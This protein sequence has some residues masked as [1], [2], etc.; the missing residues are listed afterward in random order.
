MAAERSSGSRGPA[1]D[2]IDIGEERG[3]RGAGGRRGC[4]ACTKQG[5]RRKKRKE[6]RALGVCEARLNT[7]QSAFGFRF[8]E[9]EGRVKGKKN[10]EV[11][12]M[13]ICLC[14]VV[15]PAT[16]KSDSQ[17]AGYQNTYIS[18]TERH[19]YFFL[20][21]IT[22]ATANG[23]PG[24]YATGCLIALELFNPPRRLCSLSSLFHSCSQ[25]A[26]RQPDVAK[27][28]T[29]S[30]PSEQSPPICAFSPRGKGL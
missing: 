10:L 12:W 28:A 2:Y 9:V 24:R 22:A 14:V 26:D 16:Q 6:L 15:L 7:S 13:E 23:L 17:E 30:L 27:Q 1:T 5:D 29:A 21:R 18:Q 25:A 8:Q 20:P 4:F 11:R 19:T 3:L